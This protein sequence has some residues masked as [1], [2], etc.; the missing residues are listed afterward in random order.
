MSTRPATLSRLAVAAI[1]VNVGIV[2]TGG[3]VRLTGSGLGCPDW[4]TCTA[5][6]VVP[7]AGGEA[8]WSQFIEFGNRL[9]TFV[10]LGVV[11]AVWLAA[12][13][14]ATATPGVSPAR[15][16]TAVRLASALV[17]GVLGQAVVGGITVLTGLN[18]LIVAAHFLLSMVLVAVAVVL[19]EQVRGASRAGPV[20]GP[21][22]RR[23]AVALVAVAAVVLVLGT[24]VTAAG[25]HA[26]D[27][28]TERLAFDIR[29]AVRLHTGA[30]WLAVG[31]T[32][33]VALQAG[34]RT[35]L[36]RAALVLLGVE[37]AQGTVGYLQYFTGIPAGLVAIHLLLAALFWIAAV[38][39][40][41]AAR[42]RVTTPTDRV[43][44]TS[45]PARV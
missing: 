14:Y 23:L 17:L 25:P 34:R 37:V 19:H 12:R 6:R 24:L 43:A 10:V 36:G 7:S 21:L 41:L 31:L 20:A 44:P 4:P 29:D 40:G 28:G 45:A 2:L 27:P 30:V 33:G 11:V 35:T 13:R 18:P 38:R 5:D 39:V 42:D 32:V 3:I 1:V 16:R 8:G 15:A 22:A 26:G 9:L